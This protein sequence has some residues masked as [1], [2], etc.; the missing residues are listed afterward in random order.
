MT[1]DPTEKSSDKGHSDL[2]GQSAAPDSQPQPFTSAWW[3]PGGHA[4]TLYRKFSA[5]PDLQQSRQRIELA[6]GDFIDLDWSAEAGVE[7]DASSTVVFILHGLCGCSRSPYIL[8]LQHELAR[9]RVS[10]VAMNFRGCSGEIN[11][12]ARAYH[13]GVSADLDEVMQQ[14]SLS[15]PNRRWVFVGNSLGANVLLK[16]LGERGAEALNGG[17]EVAGAVAVSTPFDL[18]ACSRAM[19]RGLS[20]LYGRYFVRKLVL[21]VMTKQHYFQ[22]TQNDEQAQVLR[23]LGDPETVR[24]IW[25]FD[26]RFTAPLH[27]FASAEDY[28]SR[29]SSKQFLS[30]IKARTLLIQ[31]ANDPLIPAAALPDP[32]MLPANVELALSD[33]GGHVGF[34]AGRRQNWLEKRIIRFATDELSR[35]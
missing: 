27:G 15:V 5:A 18:A 9:Q 22:R 19:L 33:T 13:S 26:D 8:S 16:W 24:N 6:D 31:S 12:L 2:S 10:S 21:D 28:Y 14:L 30:A 1:L 11:R 35:A 29:C 34:I 4:Q 17:G 7:Q 20:R 32:G 3:L 25:D 23:A